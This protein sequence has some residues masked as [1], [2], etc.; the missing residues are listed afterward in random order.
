VTGRV[1]HEEQL[2]GLPQG[3]TE[4]KLHLNAAALPAGTYFVILTGLPDG[5]TKAVPMI[6][7][8]KQ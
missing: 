8:N 3:V 1:L 4:Q 5:K 7:Q 2:T 6:K